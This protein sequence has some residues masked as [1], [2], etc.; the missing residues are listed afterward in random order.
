MRRPRGAAPDPGGYL[1]KDEGGPA[2]ALWT[3]RARRCFVVAH[4]PACEISRDFPDLKARA[5]RRIPHFVWGV[6][7]QCHRE[8]ER[9]RAQ[10]RQPRPRSLQA[11]SAARGD[12]GGFATTF[13]GRAYPRL[14]FGI[15]P[16]GMSG[17]V[18]PE[19][20]ILLARHAAR[21]G[22]PYGLS[23]VATA[24]ARG[25]EGRAGRSGLVPDV[26]ATRCG[27]SRR[28]AGAG[29]RR[30]VSHA[31]AD[32]G[33]ARSLAAGAPDTRAGCAA[34]A[35]DAAAGAA[36]RALPGLGHGHP[37]LG[38]AAHAADGQLRRPGKAGPPCP[39]R[40]ML[41]TC[42]APRPTGSTWPRCAKP[43]RGRSS[44]RVSWRVRSRPAPRRRA[45]IAIWVSNH[46][47]RQFD[48]APAAVLDVLPEIRAATGL[49]V[50]CDSGIAGGLDILRM[51]ALGADFVMMGRA[52]HYALGALGRAGPAHLHEH[53]GQGHDLQHGADRGR[54]A[55]RAVRT[56][57]VR[58]LTPHLHPG[59]KLPARSA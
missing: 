10:P 57:V 4:G 30:G 32:R 36:G 46:A 47:G 22:I 13:L 42:C 34:A 20:E 21:A 25:P 27:H 6:S 18:W 49:P 56:P 59:R 43:G 54:A 50:I 58:D 14:P 16:L 41:A 11:C 45:S 12:R 1:G 5:R 24:H 44:S 37:G 52:W 40:R 8:R 19:A 48:G 31:C 23:T 26:P 33:R 3:S 29:A 51:L 39:P 35:P 17:L 15:A 7:R 55:G 28:H 38:H 9:D 2:G 53:A